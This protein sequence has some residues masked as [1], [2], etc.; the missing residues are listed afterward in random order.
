MN[1][2]RSEKSLLAFDVTVELRRI[3]SMLFTVV[4][5]ENPEIGIH[6]VSVPDPDAVSIDD[7]RI[8][9]GLR[10]TVANERKTQ[11]R[12]SRRFRPITQETDGGER[13]A[14][15]APAEAPGAFAQPV[16]AEVGSW[17]GGIDSSWSQHDVISRRDQIIE[18]KNGS[19]LQ[20][21]RAGIEH[22]HTVSRH[23]PQRRVTQLMP[24]DARGTWPRATIE[25]G[26]VEARI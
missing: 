5:D 18:R 24:D 14:S 26:D 20:P 11:Q 22:S 8:H 19:Q 7:L 17:I 21:D 2:A 6:Q 4:L 25:R 1:P 12:L 23:E 16:E 9:G 3:G 15:T 13:V 10:Q